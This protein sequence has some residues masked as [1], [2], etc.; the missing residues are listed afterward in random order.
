[1]R[2]TRGF[3]LLELLAVL[4]IL[5]L[6]AAVAAPSLIR[7]SAT[8]LKSATSTIAAGLRL[9]RSRAITQNQPAA[10]WI[11]VEDRSF[12]V[13]GETRVRTLPRRIDVELFTARSEQASE[14]RGAIRFFPDGS[15][16][17]GRVTLS[18][19]K[20]RYLVDVDWLTGRV[21]VLESDE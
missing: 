8:E 11:D 9:T 21:K 19:D 3:T 18:T 5:A 1:M 16:T 6:V 20:R 10:L 15:S 12:Q 7:T 17:G 14:R 2:G 13:P 4:V